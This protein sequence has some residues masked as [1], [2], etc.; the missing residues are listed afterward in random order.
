MKAHQTKLKMLF[1]ATA[2]SSAFMSG[3]ASHS[4][5]PDHSFNPDS[6]PANLN[7]HATGITAETGW[8][9]HSQSWILTTNNNGLTLDNKSLTGNFRAEYGDQRGDLVVTVNDSAKTLVA[10]HLGK[11]LTVSSQP[12][13]FAV[14]GLC[15]YQPD[16][17]T[18]QLFILG[19]DHLARQYVLDI[20]NKNVL[21][22]IRTLPLPPETENCVVSDDL[23]TLYVSEESIG[24]WAYAAS[25]EAPYSRTAVDLVAPYG[26][27]P[28]NAGALSL[29]G[30]QLIV[31]STG[32]R[33]ISSYTI[34]P[35]SAAASQHTVPKQW[36]LNNGFEIE[37]FRAWTSGEE[38]HFSAFDD[39]SGELYQGILPLTDISPINVPVTHS[40]T[41][42]AET[43]RVISAGDAAD[44]PAIWVNSNNA[45]ASLILGTDKQYGLDVYDLTGKLKQRLDNGRLNNVD[46]R[47]NQELAGKVVDIAAASHRDLSAISLFAIDQTSGHVSWVNDIKTQ[48]DDVYGLCMAQ[49]NRGTY[50]FINDQDGRYEQYK[51]I[52]ENDTWSAER[53][54]EFALPSQPEGCVADDKNNRLFVGEEAAG[55]WLTSISADNA[56]DPKLIIEVDDNL[57]ADVEGMSI[58]HGTETSYLVVSSQG[59]D[60]Y[61]L[62]SS[63]APYEYVGRFNIAMNAAAGIDGASETDGLDVTSAALGSNYPDGLLVVQDGRNVMP[64]ENQNYKLVSWSDIARELKL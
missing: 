58:Y 57:V 37:T 24:V 29:V 38:V 59:D 15:L 27:L 9:L 21:T 30:N 62:Y 47:Y 56:P 41:P 63:E 2:I 42:T 53:V 43:T 61:V 17:Q 64:A 12:L 18:T 35:A 40:V 3:C 33:Y 34:G 51:V 1:T 44:D 23:N 31:A 16:N 13:S 28:E 26:K 48:L 60:S 5:S 52:S 22:E 11:Q 19:D 4:E 36:V 45:E 25:A 20:D 6:T 54:R 46:V 14:E 49:T 55:V 8:Q 7:V 39:A 32:E 50:V 10:H